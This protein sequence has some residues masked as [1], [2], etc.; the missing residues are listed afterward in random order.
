M[1]DPAPHPLT[2][3]NRVKQYP[4]PGKCIYCGQGVSAGR[5]TNEH[6]IPE[7]LGGTLVLQDASCDECCMETSAFEGHAVSV[8]NPIRRQLKFPSKLKGK[9]ARERD[10]TEKFIIEVDKRRIRIP[11]NEFPAL[12]LSL[13]FPLP[14]ILMGAAADD[15]EPLKGGVFSAELMDNFG[16][17]LNAIRAKYGGREIGV[18]GVDKSDRDSEGDFGRMLAK[19]G[20][21]YAV[22]ERGNN[23]FQ[24]LLTHIIR[25]RRPYHQNYFMGSQPSTTAAGTDLHEID[26]VTMPG[27]DRLLIVRIRLFANFNTPAHLVVVGEN[28]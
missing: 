15:D 17:H 11:S 28:I 9:K 18:V 22:A 6:I 20:H 7:S 5:L 23:S 8:Y 4:T 16:L 2:R 12:V 21:S 25:G 14:K 3:M 13:V 26:F 1:T 19:M 10:A 24:P 27:F